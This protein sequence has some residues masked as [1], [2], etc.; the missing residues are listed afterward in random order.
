MSNEMA[1]AVV[2]NEQIKKYMP[3]PEELKGNSWAYCYGPAFVIEND[4]AEPPAPQD[5]FDEH[6]Q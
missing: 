6:H 5:P 2:Q 4:I 1:K 3:T